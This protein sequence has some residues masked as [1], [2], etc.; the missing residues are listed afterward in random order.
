MVNNA[1]P[2]TD[3][4]DILGHQWIINRLF[5]AK[6]HA[7]LQHI[8]I[9]NLCLYFLHENNISK[10]WFKNQD[11]PS[12]HMPSSNQNRFAPAANLSCLSA[13]CRTKPKRL[14]VLL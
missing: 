4:K 14:R 12:G 11:S 6:M 2:V 1:Y 5:A 10:I 9:W 7:R 8:L 3:G 13:F